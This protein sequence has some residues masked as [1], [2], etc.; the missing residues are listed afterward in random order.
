MACRAQATL[1]QGKQFTRLRDELSKQRRE[2]PWEKAE[3]QYVFVGPAEKRRLPTF[4]G[5]S[6]LIAYHFMFSPG[7]EEDCP[8]CSLLADTRRSGL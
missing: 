5:R 1:A 7:W 8:G 4:G 6:Q 2:L 3:K